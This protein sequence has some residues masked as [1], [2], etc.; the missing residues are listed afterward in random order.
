MS[1]V[2]TIQ[3]SD[4]ISG[5]SVLVATF[6]LIVSI[7]AISS[8]KNLTKKINNINLNSHVFNFLFTKLI[9]E[10]LPE[11]LDETFNTSLSVTTL[12]DDVCVN[13]N[14]KLKIYKYIDKEFYENIYNQLIQLDDLITEQKN[15]RAGF[16][17]PTETKKLEIKIENL[18]KDL[19]EK[20]L[21]SE[22]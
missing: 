9:L 16:D 13:L 18:Y 1:T 11:A 21:N 12:L 7:V 22:K 10:E 15:R 17:I 20:Y 14:K 4:I 5:I 8:N 2:S 3:I 19:M 6:S